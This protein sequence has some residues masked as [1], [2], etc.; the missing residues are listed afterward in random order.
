MSCWEA[1]VWKII[2]RSPQLS[3]AIRAV[4]T[5]SIAAGEAAVAKRRENASSPFPP[6]A[7]YV[8]EL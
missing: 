4:S 8:L 3:E 1:A 6:S 5:D 7:Q 2:G